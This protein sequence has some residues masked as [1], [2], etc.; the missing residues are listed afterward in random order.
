MTGNLWRSRMITKI[1]KYLFFCQIDGHRNQISQ[2]IFYQNRQNR[3]V[4]SSSTNSYYETTNEPYVNLILNLIYRYHF[5]WLFS[6]FMCRMYICL[7]ESIHLFFYLSKISVIETREP[8]KKNTIRQV[9]LQKY[10]YMML[11]FRYSVTWWQ[12]VI[13][14]IQFWLKYFIPIERGCALQLSANSNI[15]TKV[16][17]STQ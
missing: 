15:S 16:L 7:K 11:K 10:L 14:H 5:V 12:P 9:F 13:L 17:L 6:Y 1:N 3:L 2:L 8:G 4:R